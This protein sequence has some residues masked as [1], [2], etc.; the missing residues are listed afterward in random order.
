[1]PTL[2]AAFGTRPEAIKMAP[3]VMALRRRASQARTLVVTTGQHRQML[4]QVLERFQL[5]PDIDLDVMRHG[6]TPAEVTARV[7]EQVTPLLREHRVD[8]VIVQGD[9]TTAMATALAAFLER[10]PVAHVEAGLRSGRLDSPF[11]EEMNRVFIDRLARWAYPPTPGSALNLLREGIP[12]DQ[13]LITGNTAIDALLWIRERLPQ[14]D[15]PIRDTLGQVERLVLI[16]AHR[17]ESFGEPFRHLCKALDR[18]A[19]AHPQVTFVYPVHPNPNV[20]TPVQELLRAPNMRLIPPVDYAEMVW[21]LQQSEL[22]L[23]DSGGVQEEAPTLGRP[24][25]VLREV[26]ERPEVVQSGAAILVGT[27]PKKIEHE[28]SRLL[29]SPRERAAFLRPRPLF[30]DGKAAERIVGHLLG[31]S[32]QPWHPSPSTT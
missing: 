16:T 24:L 10:I 32:V 25:L 13:I 19:R 4:D 8:G 31:E 21:L 9:T 2:L 17:R 26:T 29:G 27:D 20:K 30:G 7:L 28:A 12:S 5:A 1:M 22:I 14:L 6:Q 11:P 15:I 3:V 18:L 23:S